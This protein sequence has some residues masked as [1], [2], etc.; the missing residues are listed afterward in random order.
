MMD[1]SFVNDSYELSQPAT[2][3]QPQTQLA[4]QEV[5]A[6]SNLPEGVFGL[7]TGWS[8]SSSE[9]NLLDPEQRRA[10]GS[11]PSR[12]ELRFSQEGYHVGRGPRNQIRLDGKKISSTHAVIWYDH[13]DG[14]V[15]IRDHSTNGTT[16]HNQRLARGNVTVL[17]S[18]D[19]IIFGPPS[20][21]PA[22]DFRYTFQGRV[23]VADRD[24]LFGESDGG[25]IRDL[26]EVM[27]QIGKGSFATVR[28]AID[29][30]T[31]QQVAVKIVNKARFA[32]NPKTMMM[33][34]REIDIMKQLNHVSLSWV[35]TATDSLLGDRTVCS[36]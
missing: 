14:N 22:D 4:T 9:L 8:I 28:R 13:S 5:H 19:T 36:S 12:I 26:Y 33:I 10:V 16:V 35:R 21:S 7:L 31:G 11:K 15:R 23:S 17:N 29:R 27:E 3:T 2:Q 34:R 24:G 20:N 30:N 6:A 25:G 18:G 32:S 1:P